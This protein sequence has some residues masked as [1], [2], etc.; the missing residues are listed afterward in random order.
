MLKTIQERRSCRTFLDKDI[1]KEKIDKL[2]QAALW[3][4]TSKNN[5][6][7]E[8]I[9]VKDLEKLNL[10]G[11]CKPHGA[12]F[13]SQCKLAI[14]IIAD[15]DKSDVWVEDCSVAASYIQLTAEELE[16]GSCWAQI[17]NR[18]YTE[19]KSAGNYIKELFHIPDSFEVALVIGL[20]Y[21]AK[22]RKPYSESD[23]RM[24]KIHW[25]SF[26]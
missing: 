14:V 9:L 20:G 16:L 3:S 4:P 10:L 7:W 23:L 26:Q 8:F 2:I 15:P 21:K 13:L 5:R 22:D 24:E 25:E 11:Q 1:E 18:D 19:H 17:R 6:P 12:A